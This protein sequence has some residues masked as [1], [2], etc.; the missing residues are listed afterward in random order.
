MSNL[1]V[2]I[3]D[4]ADQLLEMGFKHEIEK[5]LRSLPPPE[6]RQTLLFSATVTPPV[7]QIAR[8]AMRA[9]KN[10]QFVDCIKEGEDHTHAGRKSS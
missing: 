9:G 10:Q 2:L 8:S 3:L 1:S 5:I 7:Q 4:E 6:T